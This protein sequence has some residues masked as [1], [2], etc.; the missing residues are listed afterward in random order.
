MES[1]KLPTELV[2]EMFFALYSLKDVVSLAETSR[3]LRH[4]WIEHSD[5][6]YRA[7]APT[8]I[9]GEKHA[10][11]LQ[12][13]ISGNTKITSRDAASILQYASFMESMIHQFTDKIVKR[14]PRKPHH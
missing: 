13:S 1:A 10:R 12:L 2:L 6:I 5:I 9:E 14:L 11:A 3:R 8:S 4:I 7:V